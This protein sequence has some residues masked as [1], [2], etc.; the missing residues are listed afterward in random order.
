[1]RTER[2]IPQEELAYRTNLHTT[3]VGRFERGVREPRLTTILRLA[4]GL[5]VPPSALMDDLR[6]PENEESRE[7]STSATVE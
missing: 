4:R 6:R 1:M 7:G 3:A 2:G 5:E